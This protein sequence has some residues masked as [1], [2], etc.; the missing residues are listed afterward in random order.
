MIFNYRW[1]KKVRATVS[2]ENQEPVSDITWGAYHASRSVEKEI[3][4][5]IVSLLPLFPDD[6]KSAAM[7]KHGMST[8]KKTT[9]VVNPGQVPVMAADQPLYAIAKQVQWQFPES[10]GEFV[11]MLGS[12]HVE[13]A[14]Q[15]VLGQWLEGSGWVESLIDSGVA[16][17]GRAD[18][19]LKACHVTRTRRAHQITACAL[20]ILLQEAYES[21]CET[22]DSPSAMYEW[23]SRQKTEYPTFYYWMTVLDLQLLLLVF[24]TS[25]RDGDFNL[26]VQSLIKMM[27]WFFALNHHNYSR[28]LPIHIHDMFNLKSNHPQVHEMFLK[29]NFVVNKTSRRFSALPLD[30][31]HEQNNSLVKGDGGAIGLTENPAALRRWTVGGPEVA[32]VIQEFESSL[33]VQNHRSHSELIH[34]E[35]SPSK[36]SAFLRDVN[37][38]ANQIRQFG[39]PFLEHTDDLLVLHTGD[40]IDPEVSESMQSIESQGKMQYLEFVH[41]RIE[42]RTTPLNAPIKRNKLS[43][44]STPVNKQKT[45][46]AS[47]INALKQDCNLFARLY[48]GSQSRDGNLDEFFAHENQCYPPSLSHFGSLRMGNKAQLLP[49]LEDLAVSQADKPT[50]DALIMDG[51][52][53]VHMIPPRNCSTFA[54][55][56]RNVFLPYL[57]GMLAS[58]NTRLDVVFDIYQPGSLKSAAREIRG[59]G[60]RRRVAPTTPV[61]RNW[62]GFLKNEV[63]KTELFDLLALEISSL[64]SSKH[65]VVTQ[66]G[67]ILTNKPDDKTDAIRTSTQEE[68]DTRLL[69]HLFNAYQ[70]GCRKLMIKTVDTDVVVLSIAAMTCMPAEELWIAFGT[71]RNL[72]YIPIHDISVRLGTDVCK[73]LPMFHSFTGCDT[74]SSFYSIG[75][76]TAWNIWQVFPEVTDV[77]VKLSCPCEVTDSDIEVL[78]RFTILL[79][80]RTSEETEV[81]TARRILFT[82]KNR[83]IETI[84]PTLGSLTQHIRR[85]AYQAGHIW[86]QMLIACPEVPDPGQ[87]GWKQGQPH[88]WQPLWTMEEDISSICKELVS[89]G[90]KKTCQG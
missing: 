59:Q 86:G 28:W 85:A 3:T 90:C 71:G 50:V 42:S 6:S 2:S 21:Y 15:K 32:R 43:L 8:I 67:N 27:P 35:Q 78:Q 22:T 87:W 40:I 39:N 47:Q 23:C 18:S 64:S 52:A 20:H 74:V 55:Y 80:N 5:A 37:A 26:Y 77:F 66:G 48:I 56:A 11:I 25:L 65:V 36:Q 14:F 61:P 7:I 53:I 16:S 33:E 12:L 82:Q 84:P 38:L 79:Y 44:L 76:K 70:S 75:K 58:T 62:N 45:P 49:C 57:E 81:N 4:P 13:M 31:A 30:H 89:C 34:Y 72:R 83:S 10:H 63:N 60:D 68:A 51:A 69:L 1:L 17:H 24:I 73:A 9:E 41:E 19:F 54:A 88:Q 29:G 46:A